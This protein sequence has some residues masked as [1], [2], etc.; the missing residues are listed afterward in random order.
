M[1]PTFDQVASTTLQHYRPQFAD[2]ITDKSAVMFN[3]KQR[4][5]VEEQA[6]GR[7][8]V[9]P[10]ISAENTTVGSYRDFDIIPTDP[11]EGI[12]AA[13]FPWAQLAGSLIISGRQEFVNSEN[14]TRV[15]SLIKGKTL[16]LQMTMTNEF[17]RQSHGDGSGNGGKDITGFLAAIEN[18]LAWNVYGGIDANIHLYWRN[19]WIGFAAFS[20]NAALDD[21]DTDIRDFRQVLTTFYNV[22]MRNTDKPKL[23]LTGQRVHEYFEQSMVVNERYMKGGNVSDVKMAAAGFENLMF[24]SVP[25]V[26]DN[27]VFNTNIAANASNQQIESLNTD[28]IKLIVGSGRNFVMTPFVRPPNQE[29]K[30]AQVILYAQFV[31]SNRQL[32]G[33]MDDITF[34]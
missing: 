16:Q 29:A 3:L 7:T 17:N 25:V 12:T 15:L 5:G 31:L 34:V 9:E 30:V 27:L 13:E 4:G 20:G 23:W 19:Q 33:R 24:K 2:N 14:R 22:C 18:G 26:L 21:T 32:Q 28:F 6:G 1:N 11:Q 8:L 10:L